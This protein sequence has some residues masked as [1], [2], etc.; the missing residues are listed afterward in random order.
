MTTPMQKFDVTDAMTVPWNM[1]GGKNFL[2]RALLWGAGLLLLVYFIFGR[3]FI[4]AYVGFFQTLLTL[5]ADGA[6]DEAAALAAFDGMGSLYGS[7]ILL[8][9]AAWFVMVML[10]TAM[11]KNIFRGTDKGI[12]PLR[13][14]LDEVKVMLAQFVIFICVMA[15]YIGGLIVLSIITAILG[16]TGG[17]GGAAALV[18]IFMVIGFV[19][20]IGLLIS[21]IIRWAPAAAMSVRD[22]K[23]RIFDGWGVTKG[24]SW[25]LFGAYALVCIGG[26]VLIMILMSVGMMLLF[27]GV[28]MTALLLAAESNDMPDWSSVTAHFEKTSVKVTMAIFLIAYAV[29]TLLWYMHIWG[30]G[31]YVAQLDAKNRAIS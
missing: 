24:F 16:S 27:S 20:L 25:P 14:G 7:A 6:S 9:I 23:Q 17:S 26:Y 5:D 2:I 22:D 12:V 18:V 10:E 13:F 3:A 31:N 19:A 21:L 15:V 1:P 11:H 29:F 28:D 4:T 8:S 30:I